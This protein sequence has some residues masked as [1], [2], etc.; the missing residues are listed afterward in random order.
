LDKIISL[1]EPKTVEA[2]MPDLVVE[3]KESPKAKKTVKKA[4]K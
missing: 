3:E 4:S 1:L 2:V